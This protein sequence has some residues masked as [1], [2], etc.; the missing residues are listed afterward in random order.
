MKITEVDGKKYQVIHEFFAP[1]F[2]ALEKIKTRLKDNYDDFYMI[3]GNQDKKVHYLFC[4]GIDDAEFTEIEN[5]N[6]EK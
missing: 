4:R 3:K 5:T 2:D 1:N 6:E